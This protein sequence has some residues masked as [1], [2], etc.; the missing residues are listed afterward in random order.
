MDQITASL[1][2]GTIAD[3]GRDSHLR[4][5]N[6]ATVVSLTHSEPDTGFPESVTVTRVPITDGPQHDRA[7]FEAAVDAVLA[8][9]DSGESV[10]VHCSRGAS[11]SPSVAATALALS[12]DVGIDRAFERVAENRVV[13]DPHDALVRQAVTVYRER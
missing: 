12:R 2:V 11:R 4:K 5:E 7:Q 1:F 3:A 9:L 6:I 8:A 10:L 13:T